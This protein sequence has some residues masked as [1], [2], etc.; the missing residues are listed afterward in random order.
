MWKLSLLLLSIFAIML[1]YKCLAGSYIRL[2]K[3]LGSAKFNVVYLSYLSACSCHVTYA[4]FFFFL[5]DCN[6]T[7]TYKHLVCKR[8]LNHL[9]K[10]TKWL[11]YVV[12]TYLYG[13]FDCMFLSLFSCLNVK[14]LLARK[15]RVDSLW[16]AYVTWYRHTDKCTVQI[17]SHDTAKSFG[18]F[19]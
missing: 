18:Q 19:G 1:Q 6:W 9:A 17:S 14:E 3:P 11:N 2:S 4:F 13:A 15:R 12:R 10:L 5:S 16:N 8:T 7:R